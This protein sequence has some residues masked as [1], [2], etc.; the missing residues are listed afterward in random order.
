M[1]YNLEVTNNH[2]LANKFASSLNDMIIADGGKGVFPEYAIAISLDKAECADRR[3]VQLKTMDS[4][5]G[6]IARKF[7]GKKC[8]ERMLMCEFRCNYK[9]WRNISITELEDKIENSRKLLQREYLGQIDTRCFFIFNKSVFEQVRNL[10]ARKYISN[11]KHRVI[12]TEEE[13]RNLI[14]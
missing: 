2:P 12:I 11:T 6:V 5:L 10:F 1:V 14:F 3:A 8:Y 13:F 4:A 9:N 7:S